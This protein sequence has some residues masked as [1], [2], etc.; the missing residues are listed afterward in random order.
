MPDP[1]LLSVLESLRT[2][3]ALGEE[4]LARAI[5][6]AEAFI[7]AIPDDAAALVDLGSGGGLPALVI[8]VERPG[9]RVVMTDR[10]E[11]R[12]DLLRLACVRLGLDDRVTVLTGDVTMLGREAALAGRFDVVTARAFGAPLWTASCA[13]PFLAPHGSVIVSEPPPDE[14]VGRR[15]DDDSLATLGLRRS[16]EDFP[17]VQ[18]LE[19]LPA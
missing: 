19:R 18:R 1:E 13:V 11:R 12:M 15:W 6:H 4:S 2:R 14:R 16:A 10:R 8:A 17:M 5:A 3:G 9:L 7:A